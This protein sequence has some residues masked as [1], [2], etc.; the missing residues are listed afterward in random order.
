MLVK[1]VRSFVYQKLRVEKKVELGSRGAGMM[2]E[3]R[4]QIEAF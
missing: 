2:T 4:F 1:L 3:G